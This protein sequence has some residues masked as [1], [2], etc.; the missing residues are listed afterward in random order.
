MCSLADVCRSCQCP[1]LHPRHLQP[2]TWFRFNNVHLHNDVRLYE[3]N[4]GLVYVDDLLERTN[5]VMHA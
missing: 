2:T 1:A 3:C 4:R 5:F